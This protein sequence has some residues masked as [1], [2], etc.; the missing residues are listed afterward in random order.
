M[1]LVSPHRRVLLGLAVVGLAVAIGAVTSWSGGGGVG[2][3]TASGTT[4]GTVS[5]VGTG[6]TSPVRAS[7]PVDPDGPAPTFGEDAPAPAAA[8]EPLDDGL[9]QVH[10][11]NSSQ[12]TLAAAAAQAVGPG[13]PR[14]AAGI[15]G[16]QAGPPVDPEDVL[17]VTA[18]RGGCVLE[19]GDPGQCLPTR[20]PSTSTVASTSGQ[21]TCA[22]VRELFPDG[23]AAGGGDPLRLDG[24]GDGVACGPG[25]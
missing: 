10:P 11:G 1:S 24:D 9:E 14:P 6:G 16:D 15:S 7:V 22:G 21:W 17:S 8:A 2:P 20:P 23:L 25:D 4:A 19:Y 12:T 3:R 5:R 18:A 13:L